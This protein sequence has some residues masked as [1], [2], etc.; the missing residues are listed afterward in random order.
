MKSLNVTIKGIVQGVGFRPFIFKLASEMSV[1]GFITNTSDG[2]VMAVEGDNLDLFLNRVRK[3]APPLARIMSMDISPM[4]FLGFPDFSIKGSSESGRFTLLSPDI[5]VC[6]DCLDELFDLKDRR[7]LYPFINCTNCGPR[8]SITKTVPY[9]RVNT[10]MNT[11]RMCGACLSE[12][13][14]PGN[15]RFH[16][17]PNACPVCGP[18][19]EL[20]IRSDGM[21]ISEEDDTAGK[22]K[23]FAQT[24]ENNSDKGTGWVSYSLR[25][26][27]QGSCFAIEGKKAQKQQ[28]FCLNGPGYR[29]DKKILL[30]I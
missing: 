27:K 7:F 23:G 20:V 9:D 16:A 21:K 5:S 24:R 8:Y 6:N 15:R 22:D 4:K 28:T 12:Y 30:C 18:Q 1:N 13:Q 26:N 10:T 17:Q 25:R 3:D 11:F 29:Y 14:N 2:V 19:L